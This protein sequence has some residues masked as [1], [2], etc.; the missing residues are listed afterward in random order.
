MRGLGPQALPAE[1]TKGRSLAYRIDAVL[2]WLASR[3]GE[4]FDIE[5]AHRGYLTSIHMPP[6]LIWVRRLA[7]REGPVQGSVRF[8][9]QGWQRHLDSLITGI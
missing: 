7:E 5:A 4:P 1:W 2:S 8:T 9:S 3:Q 6:D